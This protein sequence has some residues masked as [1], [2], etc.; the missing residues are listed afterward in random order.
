MKHGRATM[1]Q[2]LSFLCFMSLTALI[3]AL[4]LAAARAFCGR[5]ARTAGALLGVMS[6]RKH[7]A[8]HNLLRVFPELSESSRHRILR[9]M[10][11]NLGR[12]VADYMHLQRFHISLPP[13]LSAAKPW[14]SDDG[15]FEVVGLENLY[16][17]RTMKQGSII[18]SAHL[19]SWEM[20]AV[21]AA[22]AGL[23]ISQLYRSASNPLIDRTIRKAQA[24]YGAELINKNIA[25]RS[26]ARALDEGR[27]VVM[28]SDQ[29]TRGGALIPFMGYPA[30]TAPG[31][32]RFALKK[33]CT[34]TPAF[35]VRLP[36]GR[37]QVTFEP[38]LEV[39]SG[40][41]DDSHQQEREILTTMNARFE[42][43]IRRF[44]EQ[45]LWIHDR[46]RQY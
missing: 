12:T 11:D 9:H 40:S 31:V 17:L 2:R 7:C 32:A 34:I 22:Q 43:W 16:K 14:T 18:F 24:T 15:L 46:W 29:R 41:Y 5:I 35:A 13:Q 26:I 4:P 8:K 1:A 39:P 3:R 6:S 33:G 25:L 44:P 27:H 20:V 21:I 23:P 30:L 45:W 37:V 42:H 28:L 38:P 36:C 19:G 10:W